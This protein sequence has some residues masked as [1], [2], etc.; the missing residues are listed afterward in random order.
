LQAGQIFADKYEIIRRVGRGGMGAVFEAKHVG[1]GGLVAIKV[2]VSAELGEDTEIVRRFQREARAAGSIASQ[3]IVRVFDTGVDPT[4]GMPFM[5]MDLL[6]GQDLAHL[7]KQ[8][9]PLPSDLALRIVGQACQGLSK[10]HEAG[11]VHRDIKPAN[12]FLADGDGDDIVVKILDF[13]IAKV[14]M[15]Q[16]H[17]T[18]GGLT[19]TGSVLGSPQ[20]MSPEQVMASKLIDHRTDIWSMGVVLYKLLSGRTPLQGANS[21]G[22]I[23]MTVTS[24]PARPLQEIAPWVPLEVAAIV[25]RALQI[26]PERRF[27]TA[28]EMVDAIRACAP[29]GLSV[30]RLMLSA[31]TPEERQHVAARLEIEQS[32]TDRSPAHSPTGPTS[33]SGA[34]V[35]ESAVRPAPS[36]SSRRTV[37]AVAGGLLAVALSGLAGARIR[38]KGA[39]QE[40]AEAL[41]TEVASAA[42]SSA[43]VAPSPAVSVGDPAPTEVKLGIQPSDANVEIDGKKVAVTA[44]AVLFSG[45]LGSVHI[46]RVR[47]EGHEP[48]DV[49]VVVTMQGPIP[50]TIA[51]EPAKKSAV[52]QQPAA[53][54]TAKPPTVGTPAKPPATKPGGLA[55]VTSFD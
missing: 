14:K 30:E 28:A 20:Y 7:A 13:G 3:H 53:P 9:G 10:A 34:A 50:P 24:K 29:G 4:N 21:L 42:P 27:D 17:N 23:M 49:D 40:P 6:H 38:S 19:R 18:E 22:E 16:M 8:L 36:G 55:P 52:R 31:V 1:T 54:A 46:V 47:R 39:P 44:S 15:E 35:A 25:H 32:T 37:L 11:V 5:V 26:K 48:R 2:M 12:I 45:K 43:V 41:P 51:L 33:A